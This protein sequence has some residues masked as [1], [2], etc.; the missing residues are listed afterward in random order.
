M[1]TKTIFFIML[2]IGINLWGQ[3]TTTPTKDETQRW[4]KSVIQTYTSGS[5]TFTGTGK[6]TFDDPYDPTGLH[7]TYTVDISNLGGVST[8][9][10]TVG[11]RAIYLK[12]YD[13]KCV[14]FTINSQNED[15]QP[16][17]DWSQTMTIQ[18]RGDIPNGLEERIINAF[19]HLIKLYGGN[20]IDNTF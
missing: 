1:K 3:N 10:G 12:C 17:T 14:L 19:N 18:L 20:T 6:M 2:M 11:H 13:S 16:D 9:G 7:L 15:S 4:L 5:L 8:S